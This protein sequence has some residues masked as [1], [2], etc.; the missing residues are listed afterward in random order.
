MPDKP[1]GIGGTDFDRA[2]N[3]M[4]LRRGMAL[5]ATAYRR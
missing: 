1:C 4:Q 2:G 5:A 3:R